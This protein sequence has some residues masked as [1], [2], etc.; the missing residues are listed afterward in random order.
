MK[1]SFEV[2][3]D[4]FSESFFCA[5]N[6]LRRDEFVV[7]LAPQWSSKS[8]VWFDYL[9]L[10]RHL[11]ER[12]VYASLLGLLFMA[13]IIVCITFAELFETVLQAHL[14]M[15]NSFFASFNFLV[16][17]ILFLLTPLTSL[18]SLT[19]LAKVSVLGILALFYVLT[20]LIYGVVDLGISND[21]TVTKHSFGPI[22]KVHYQNQYDLHF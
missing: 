10:L 2:S 1:N 9:G 13:S 4:F 12:V 11:G 21:V 22:H 8:A 7:C 14:G 18:D 17:F 15:E 20:T 16:F 19:A 6:F 3:M 5:Q